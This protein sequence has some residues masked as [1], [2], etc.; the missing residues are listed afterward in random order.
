MSQSEESSGESVLGEWGLTP[1][2]SETLPMQPSRSLFGDLW[3]QML[4]QHT[5]QALLHVTA[6]VLIEQIVGRAHVVCPCSPAW[7]CPLSGTDG[8]L[9]GFTF[10]LPPSASWL[11][12]WDID[13]PIRDAQPGDTIIVPV[14][15]LKAV[16]QARLE[17]A[18]KNNILL[19]VQPVLDLPVRIVSGQFAGSSG[20]LKHIWG[21]RAYVHINEGANTNWLALHEMAVG[22]SDRHIPVS[23]SRT[24]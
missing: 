22:S 9:M 11:D 8:T 23:P 19:V 13:L 2:F 18:S 12:C 7:A 15:D 4:V 6:L 3:L 5:I 21:W 24:D 14:E 16:V 10:P 17:V 20:L 1:R